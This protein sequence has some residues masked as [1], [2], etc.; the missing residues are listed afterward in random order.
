MKLKKNDIIKVLPESYEYWSPYRRYFEYIIVDITEE[1]V[2]IKP[3]NPPTY[4]ELE[5]MWDENEC[6]ASLDDYFE[7]EIDYNISMESDYDWIELEDIISDW[8]KINKIC[9]P[10]E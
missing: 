10:D 2:R 4:D 1:I 9:Y 3:I 5:S 7:N 8:Y 6:Q